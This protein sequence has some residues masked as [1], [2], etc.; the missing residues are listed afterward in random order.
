MT[1]TEYICYQKYMHF[2]LITANVWIQ[3]AQFEL[4]H[5][6]QSFK[7]HILEYDLTNCVFRYLK[8][9]NEW[10]FPKCPQ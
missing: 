5:T 4:A 8:K 2:N 3:C 1:V 7:L 6:K 9:N 10:M